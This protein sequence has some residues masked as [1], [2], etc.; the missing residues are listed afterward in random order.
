MANVHVK[1]VAYI[2]SEEYTIVTETGQIKAVNKFK[3]LGSTLEATGATTLEIEKR[4]SE[5]RRVIGVLNS[6]LWSKNIL[7]KTTK[8]HVPGFSPK[9]FTI[10]GR[11]MDTKHTTGEQ[12]TG[13]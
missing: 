12:I 11:N 10:W 6:V 9:Y 13:D 1:R 4:I 7:H 5:G 8:T 2:T 3:Y